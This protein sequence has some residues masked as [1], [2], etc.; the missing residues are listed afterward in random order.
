VAGAELLRSVLTNR[1]VVALGR[2]DF[3]HQPAH[4]PTRLGTALALIGTLRYKVRRLNPHA[5][6]NWRREFHVN[7]C[8]NPR[9]R[10]GYCAPADLV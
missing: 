7:E 10:H 8:L 4:S 9:S 2:P 5:R 3:A 6:W 1:S